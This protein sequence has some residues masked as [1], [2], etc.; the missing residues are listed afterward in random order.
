MSTGAVVMARPI[1][2]SQLVGHAETLRRIEAAERAGRLHHALL[3]CGPDGV[4]KRSAGIALAARLLC[5]Q[6]EPW[7]PGGL[8]ACA[9]CHA[10][11][12][13]VAG[14]HPDLFEIS[15]DGRYLKIE[16]VR[17][18]V[19]R[20]RLRPAEGGRRVIVI[21]AAETLRDEAAN[22]LLKTLEEPGAETHFVLVTPQPHRL[23]PTVRSRCQRIGFAP[24]SLVDVTAVLRHTDPGSSA[25]IAV[26]R[27]SEGSPSRAR[28]LADNPIFAGRSEIVTMLTQLRERSIAEVLSVSESWSRNR[29]ELFVLLDLLRTVLRDAMM[30]RAGA[31]DRMLHQDLAETLKPWSMTKPVEGWLQV[32]QRVEQADRELQGN[33]HPRM[34]VENLLLTLRD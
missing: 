24:L 18:L 11:R 6:P 14:S 29:E 26:A 5:V 13:V 19:T 23:L 17:D 27:L 10:C 15:P 1:R 9:H 7:A 31:A 20:T 4:G 34:V 21:D 32:L 28:L 12:K 2:F 22:A 33:V 8:E 3:F 25:A 30:V 16:Q